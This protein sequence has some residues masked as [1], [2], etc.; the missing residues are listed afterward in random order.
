MDQ[1]SV[2]VMSFLRNNWKTLLIAALIIAGM[3]NYE[4][5]KAGFIDGWN[6]SQQPAKS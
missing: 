3:A 6:M 5:I 1:L 4:D 2:R